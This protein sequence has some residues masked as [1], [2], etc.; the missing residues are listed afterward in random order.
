MS[1]GVVPSS[2]YLI[3]SKILDTAVSAVTFDVSSFAGVYKH[4]QIVMVVRGTWGDSDTGHNV[5]IRFN[6]ASSTY[7]G[8]FLR[9]NGSA[10]AS[11]SSSEIALNRLPLTN[12]T[13]FYGAIVADILDPFSTTKNTTVRSLGGM[14][15]SFGNWIEIGSG[16]YYS[17]DPVNSINI[18]N[19]VGNLAAGSRFSL[20]GVTA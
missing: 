1:A 6:G 2:E 5:R 13:T 12:T 20:Y 4:L 11:G 19:S 17:T 9:G 3:E 14:A 16:A 18:A 7:S 8:H 10:V 15:Q